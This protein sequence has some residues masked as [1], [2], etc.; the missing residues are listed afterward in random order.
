ME[1]NDEFIAAA[2][3]LHAEGQR[4]HGLQQQQQQQ[5]QK[6]QFLLLEDVKKVAKHVAFVDQVSQD[7]FA[8]ERNCK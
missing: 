3:V 7:A 6:S 4:Q 8:T 5:G 2:A 1:D